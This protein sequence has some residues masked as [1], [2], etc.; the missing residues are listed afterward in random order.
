M[1][2][3]LL[4]EWQMIFKDPKCS[5]QKNRRVWPRFQCFTVCITAAW[6][7]SDSQTDSMHKFRRAVQESE[8][9]STQIS[10][11]HLKKKYTFCKVSVELWQNMWLFHTQTPHT[12]TMLTLDRCKEHHVIVCC[13]LSSPW[14][15][16]PQERRYR[17]R[18]SYLKTTP[19]SFG[20]NSAKQTN[21]QITEYISAS[22]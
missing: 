11:G 16:R 8:P 20:G 6:T 17:S 1:N 15:L 7:R 21:N 22:H 18:K 5:D 12:L 10:E 13:V 2:H 3:L 9:G 14:W 4:C 19:G